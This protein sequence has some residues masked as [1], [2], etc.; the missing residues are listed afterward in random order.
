MFL[1]L[2]NGFFHVLGKMIAENLNFFGQYFNA[3]SSTLTFHNFS[4]NLERRSCFDV[5]DYRFIQFIKIYYD[6][7]IVNRGTIIQSYKSVRTECAHPT[8]NGN[9]V[10]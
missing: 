3:L 5:F 6:L 9:I 8:L 4:G 7:Q 2:Q 10:V 1:G